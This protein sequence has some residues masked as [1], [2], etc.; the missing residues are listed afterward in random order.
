MSAVPILAVLAGMGVLVV[1]ADALVRGAS[2]LAAAAGVSPLVVGLTVVAYGTSAPELA[3]SVGDALTGAGEV[4][5]GNAVGSN[6]FNILAILGVAAL[7]GG[8]VVHQRLVRVDVPLLIGVTALVWWRAAD[9][10]L[11][12]AE[13]AVLVAGILAYSAFSYVL[14]RRESAAVAAEYD[15][16]FGEEPAAARRR[17]P[18]AVG[19]VA[20]G[21]VALVAGA[22]ALVWGATSMAEALGVSE[23]VIGLTVVAAGTSL[24]ELATSVVATRRGERDIAVGN[25]VGSNLFNLLAVLGFSALAGGGVA[26]PAQAISTDLPVALLV[27]AIALPAL[28][29]GLSVVRWEGT[30]LLAAYVAYVTYLVGTATRGATDV[31]RIVL[32]GGLAALAVVITAAGWIVERRR[33]PTER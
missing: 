12:P 29:L 33:R 6:V 5:V 23:L 13:G 4:A 8:L 26:V 27:T 15:E 31:G 14:G 25:I 24:P 3:V 16:A 20:L 22:R 11:S 28:A 30:L 17:W 18:A 32:L 21:L 19:L 9:G 10:T 2:R 7:F 1:G